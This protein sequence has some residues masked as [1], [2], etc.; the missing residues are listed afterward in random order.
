MDPPTQITSAN[1][2]AWLQ[3]INAQV[4]GFHDLVLQWYGAQAATPLPAQVQNDPDKLFIDVNTAMA[5]AINL[6]QS[7]D[8]AEYDSLG[9]D[10]YAL[11]PVPIDKAIETMLFYCGKPLGQTEGE[12]YPPQDGIFASAHCSMQLKWG[13]GN[14]LSTLSYT[15]GGVVN[16]LNDDLTVL[17]RGNAA[18]GYAIFCNFLAPTAGKQSAT[19][20]QIWIALLRAGPGGVTELRHCLRRNGQSYAFFGASG[21]TQFGFNASRTRTAEKGVIGSMITLNTTGTIPQNH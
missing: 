2:R 9:F 1:Y 4:S 20:A 12:T 18:E 6:E 11:V 5:Q 13:P 8:V 15:G 16:E 14:Y 17:V 7:G 21:R 3:S 19:T 10:A